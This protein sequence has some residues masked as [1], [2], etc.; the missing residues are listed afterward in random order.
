LIFFTGPSLWGLFASS[1]GAYG[2][3]GAIYSC[4]GTGA[5]AGA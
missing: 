4:F 3:E 5:G 2:L 1:F